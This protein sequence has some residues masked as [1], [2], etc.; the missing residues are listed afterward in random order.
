MKRLILLPIKSPIQLKTVSLKLLL[1]IAS[2]V[3]FEGKV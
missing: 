3:A 1:S 2:L